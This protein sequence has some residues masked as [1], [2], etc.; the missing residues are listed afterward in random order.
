MTPQFF[1]CWWSKLKR[2]LSWSGGKDSSASISLCYENGIHLDGVV[3]SEVMF[4]HSRN[5]SGENPKHIKWV[6]E[7]A[8]PTIGRMGYPVIVVRDKED[9]LSLFNHRIEKSKVEERIGKKAGWLLGG[10]CAAND[11]LKMRPLREFFKSVGECEQVVGIALDEPERLERL[12]TK[13]N[14]WSILEKKEVIETAT[15]P[16]CTKY[17]LLSPIYNKRKRGGCWFCPN[18]EVEEYAVLAKEYPELWA[19]LEKLSYDKEI[20]SQ[21]FK[22]GHTFESVNR[23]VLFFIKNNKLNETQL[24]IFD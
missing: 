19:E 22:Y 8:K 11:R 5:I 23:E 18:C 7:V 6:Y 15:Y 17:N 21:G 2:F 4:D 3:M 24:S 13:K 14:R 1:Y 12:H 20:V 10:M 9:Y 16:L